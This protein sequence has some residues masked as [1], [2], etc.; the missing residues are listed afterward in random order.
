METWLME[1]LPKYLLIG[2]A[3]L[4][5]FEVGL[6]IGIREGRERVTQGVSCD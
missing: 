1:K 4:I 2:I 6:Q 5:V 3:V